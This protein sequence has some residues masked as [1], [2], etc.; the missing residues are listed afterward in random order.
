MIEIATRNLKDSTITKNSISAPKFTDRVYIQNLDSLICF[1]QRSGQVA[2]L[3]RIGQNIDS[4]TI[5]LVLNGIKYMIKYHSS[6]Y[7]TIKENEIYFTIFPYV[8]LDKF[9]ELPLE[10]SYSLSEH[11]I[12][13][14]F[15]KF[16]KTYNYQKDWGALGMDFT[17]CK[18]KSGE[19][20]YN[21]PF[22][23]PIIKYSNKIL[24]TVSTA[25]SNYFKIFPPE[26]LNDDSLNYAKYVIEFANTTSFY[27]SLMY[28]RFKD[29][30]IRLAAHEQ[31]LLNSTI[32]THATYNQFNDRNWSLM[33]YN[34]NFEKI[35][36]QLFEGK[37]YNFESVNI[38]DQGLFI[39]KTLDPALNTTMKYTFYL[40][41]YEN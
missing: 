21:F 16:P 15:L 27:H 18:N 11:K 30:Y 24:T 6:N 38:T 3:N 22:T 2:I 12:T 37:K 40:F 14:L 19:L 36:E 35:N 25:S 26:Y 10:I 32:Y 41:K 31:S 29:L 34:K 8:S 4:F 33:F 17:K 7:I 9:Y 39:A 5:P 20:F 13:S 23:N 28:D 1:N